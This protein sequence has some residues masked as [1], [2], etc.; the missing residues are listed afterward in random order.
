MQP[1]A[2][3]GGANVARNH[4]RNEVHTQRGQDHGIL[5]EASVRADNCPVQITIPTGPNSTPPA[6]RNA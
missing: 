4:P 6:S 5:H 1:R 2:R 3:C